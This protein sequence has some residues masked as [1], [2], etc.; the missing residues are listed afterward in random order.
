MG[1][2]DGLLMEPELLLLFIPV[3]WEGIYSVEGFNI[4]CLRL[5]TV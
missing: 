3:S 1:Y 2:Y 5:T 4:Q